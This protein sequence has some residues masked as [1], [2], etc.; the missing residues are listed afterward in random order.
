MATISSVGIGSGLDVN[1]I[2]SQLVAIEKQPL[3]ALGVKATNTTNQ[4]SA[5]ADIQ[6]QFAALTDV[7]T[8]LSAASAW[9][10]R[11][12][13]S[14]NTS[15]A[16]ITTTSTANATTFTLDVDQLAK[17]QSTASPQLATGSYV[18]AGK[19]TFSLGTWTGLAASAVA[20]ASAGASAAAIAATTAGSKALSEAK[21]VDSA[22]VSFAATTPAAAAFSGKY[23][24]WV[25][26]V[27]AN[28]HVTP[29]LQTAENA[30]LAARNT[31]YS[32]L[33]VA[34]APAQTAAN[35][36]AVNATAAGGLAAFAAGTPAAAAYSTKYS[37]WVD[38][39]AGN[40]HAT[41]ALQTAEDAAL[42]ARD[43]AYTDLGSASPAAQ[44]A[45]NAVTSGA[46]YDTAAN[47][48]AAWK[49]AAT[50]SLAASGARP[51]FAA[52]SGSDFSIDATATDTVA[53][54]AAKINAANKGV[55]ATAFNDGGFDRLL[56]SSKTTGTSGGFRVQA[57]G[58]ADG[59]N[60]DNTGLSRLAYDPAVGAFGMASVGAPVQEGQ[61]AKARLNGLAVTSSSNTLAGNLPGVTINLLATTA[62][63]TATAAATQ[64]AM[65]VSEDVTVAVKNVSDFVT[66]YNNLNTTLSGLTKYNAATKTSGL[67]QGDS[68]IT[69]LQNLL[70]NMVGS[71]SLGATS[72]RLSDI[73]IEASAKLDG[74]LDIN[75]PKLSLA[76]NNGTALQ[77]LFTTDN[78]NTTT[79]GFALKF[80]DLGVGI[81]KKD[82][83]GTLFNKSEALK[84]VLSQ[85]ALA[86][87]KVNDK[88][89]LFETRLRKQYSALDAQMAQLTALNTYVTQQV[90]QWNK[91]TA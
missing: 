69:S 22:L 39:V 6:S 68:T 88:A 71:A 85:N 76:A 43:T 24:A 78:S 61:D 34:D 44:T 5:F 31:A 87:T 91:S 74:S 84:N 3:T 65:S 8:R 90:A 13:T 50:A 45:A 2:V 70:R 77:Q 48:V 73:G 59:S 12:A 41:P 28:D 81:A 60:F 52:T 29:A 64:V 23:T 18:G 25:A 51:T 4:I 16:T 56:L 36:L 40:D 80:R 11:T 89:A 38:A 20:D 53:T 83:H 79:N 7:S 35:A 21:A 72:Q 63:A 46:T 57:S 10:A 42:L 54:L 37:A 47:D 62:P 17:K 55:V 86:Q 26:A 66:A 9:S 15:I 82:G 33:G 19:L 67:F 1:S 58:S 30:A 32:D 14:S 27:A 49:T 75:T